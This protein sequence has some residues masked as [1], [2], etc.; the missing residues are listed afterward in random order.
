MLTRLILHRHGHVL[1]TREAHE[2]SNILERAHHAAP[3]HLVGG[4]TDQVNTVELDRARVG[5]D[6]AGQQV[7]YCRLSGAVWAHER[8]DR[9]LVQVH[10]EV[11]GGDDATEVLGQPAYLQDESAGPPR[12]FLGHLGIV[13]RLVFVFVDVLERH[14]G[15]DGILHHLDAGPIVASSAQSAP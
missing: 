10:G 15:G 3:R 9:A 6:V 4:M 7:E 14:D 5:F 8:G 1:Q 2:Q 13:G 11:F 12:L